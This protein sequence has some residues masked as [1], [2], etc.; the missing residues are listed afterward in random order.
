[1]ATSRRLFLKSGAL[2]AVAA[3]FGLKN[4]KVALAQGRANDYSIP[5]GVQ[6]QSTF[7]FNRGSFE[8]YINGIFQVPDATGAFVNLTLL[9]V[10]S[11]TPNR[12]TRISTTTPR[13]SDAFSLMF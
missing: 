3:G 12:Q 10:T 13:Q 7:L 6:R 5:L 1:M 4:V 2:A 8:P 11:Y 9:S